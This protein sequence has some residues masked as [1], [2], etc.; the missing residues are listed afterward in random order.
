MTLV[1]LPSLLVLSALG[2]LSFADDM[3][4]SHGI[5]SQTYQE[6]GLT[7]HADTKTQLC[8]ASSET[9]PH[10]NMEQIACASLAKRSEWLPIITWL[11]AKT[12][13]AQA[14]YRPHR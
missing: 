7:Y 14:S 5:Y 6:A 9:Q 8:F 13:E 11:P 4:S 1:K 2:S 10:T 3:Q 12:L